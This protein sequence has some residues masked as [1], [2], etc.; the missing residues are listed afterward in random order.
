MYCVSN[1]QLATSSALYVS[2]DMVKWYI[3]FVHNFS[4]ILSIEFKTSF[5]ARGSKIKDTTGIYAS[6]EFSIVSIF[7][8]VLSDDFSQK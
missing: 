4:T 6:N 5:S 3:L 8:G 2:G 7:S 1:N